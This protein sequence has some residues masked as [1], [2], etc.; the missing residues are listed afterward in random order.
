MPVVVPYNRDRAV[1]YA[2]EFALKRDENFFDFTNFGGNCTAFV[3][4]CL[5]Y[6]NYVMNPLPVFGWYY[7]NSY[8]RSASW[9]GVNFLYEFLVNNKTKA[10]FAKECL[11]SEIELGDVIQLKFFG[12]QDFTHS[13]I[14]TNI[15]KSPFD[16]FE[17]TPK[18]IYVS[19]N[20]YDALNRNLLSYNYEKIRYLKILGVYV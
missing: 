8:N 9:S 1:W 14:I 15:V 11:V 4:Q 2:K 3:S 7:Y 16:N 17:I 19:S 5:Y 12:E 10:P 20:T 13:L 6:A 18:N